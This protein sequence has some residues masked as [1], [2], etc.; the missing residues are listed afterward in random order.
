MEVKF[1]IGKH[2][3]RRPQRAEPQRICRAAWLTPWPSLI[4]KLLSWIILSNLFLHLRATQHMMELPL[5]F[6]YIALSG[7]T[8]REQTSH[9]IIQQMSLS[10]KL[11]Q[12]QLYGEVINKE[13][14]NPVIFSALA[15]LFAQKPQSP[16]RKNMSSTVCVC[17]MWA[18]SCPAQAHAADRGY[19][20]HFGVQILHHLNEVLYNV[21]ALRSNQF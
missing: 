7:M 19:R 10:N 11:E 18:D 12:N 5:R 13:T 16:G 15:L 8:F 6:L 9:Q 20:G 4:F 1:I 21:T 17:T 3:D 2:S 14:D